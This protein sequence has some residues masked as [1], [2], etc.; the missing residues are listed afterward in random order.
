MFVCQL[1]LEGK[2]FLVRNKMKIH[3]KWNL[4]NG[5]SNFQFSTT[6]LWLSV[7]MYLLLQLFVVFFDIN[8]ALFWSI[9]LFT[10]L[11]N[12]ICLP[13]LFLLD[14]FLILFVTLFNY[15]MSSYL[16]EKLVKYCY[17][18]FT[19]LKDHT[20]NLCGHSFF[21]LL[22]FYY[23]SRIVLCATGKHS[24]ICLLLLIFFLYSTFLCGRTRA[25]LN[26]CPVKT[27]LQILPILSISIKTFP[28]KFRPNI[29]FYIFFNEF[30]STIIALFQ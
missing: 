27:P 18:R 22:L 17:H 6:Y 2:I 10:L 4:F 15:K 20:F 7:D 16:V 8:Y 3:R 28:T 23:F 11:F 19:L 30:C 24:R 29:N 25:K 26:K 1:A 12:S 21:L 9:N 5:I 13:G 14:L